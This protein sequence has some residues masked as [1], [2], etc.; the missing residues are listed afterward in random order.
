V[1]VAF[2]GAIE[3]RIADD[4]N[5]FVAREIV[6]MEEKRAKSDFRISVVEMR[7]TPRKCGN[8]YIMLLLRR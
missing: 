6:I 1:N 8:C 4:G 7:A 5:Y 3:N 2:F